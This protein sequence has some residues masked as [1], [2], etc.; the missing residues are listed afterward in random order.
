MC[1]I[2]FYITSYL[3]FLIPG[4]SALMQVVLTFYITDPNQ[5]VI[6]F[7]KQTN[8]LVGQ[9]VL[10]LRDTA[11]FLSPQCYYNIISKKLIVRV[12]CFISLYMFVSLYE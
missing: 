9:V 2:L 4:V 10:A 6:S 5:A 11:N 1:I 3:A 8:I 12:F 7:T